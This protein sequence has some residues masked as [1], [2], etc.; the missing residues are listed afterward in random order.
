MRQSKKKTAGKPAPLI[1][2]KSRID[3][4]TLIKIEEAMNN[5][6]WLAAHQQLLN[7]EK[8]AP[9]DELILGFLLTTAFELNDL[10]SIERVA[11]TLSEI[12][13][14]DPSHAY[15]L[16]AAYINNERAVLAL[17][18][19]ERFLVRW[20]N[21]PNTK[22]ISGKIGELRLLVEE[23]L[24]KLGLN[25]PDGIEL[26][27]KHEES[28]SLLAIGEYVKCRQKAD[29]ILKTNPEFVPALN[30]KSL[31]YLY[32]GN[33]QEAI[34]AAL[35]VLDFEPDNIHAL[36]N[37]VRFHFAIG[38]REKAFPFAERLKASNAPAFMR[39]MKIAEALT[40]VGDYAGVLETYEQARQESKGHPFEAAVCHYAA[41]ASYHLGD[42]ATARRLWLK[43]IDLTPDM[44]LYQENLKD[45]DLP[46][47]E[48]HG[49]SVFAIDYWLVGRL[50]YA[51]HDTITQTNG[52]SIE[53]VERAQR[54]LIRQYPNIIQAA[55]NILDFGGHDDAVFMLALADVAG[56]PELLDKVKQFARGNR[57]SDELRLRALTIIQ[58]AGLTTS[59]EVPFIINGKPTAIHQIKYEIYTEGQPEEIPPAAYNTYVAATN[60]HSQ[61]EYYKAEMLLRHALT[62]A[63]ESSTIKNN[64]AA[65][66]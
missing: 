58:K 51:M 65:A 24:D 64:L 63:P 23:L 52:L 46:I 53:A 1:R 17:K 40:I 20:P 4:A 31:S 27:V 6:Q 59:D 49:T 44:Y 28:Q 42:K 62:L 47:T 41:V 18:T 38:Q 21:H 19:Y 12:R 9:H 37:L 61:G 39:Y 45:M 15:N 66:L 50:F 13:P 29:L 33:Y 60:L 10:H 48:R 32:E 3:A 8:H 56:S 43:A 34:D 5:G 57:G 22:T 26:I 35:K 55:I 54:K 16:G 7:Q 25:T 2:H 30:N 14:Q 11:I 36:S